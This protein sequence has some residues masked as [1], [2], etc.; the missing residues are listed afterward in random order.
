MICAGVLVAGAATYHRVKRA[1]RLRLA[2]SAPAP[3]NES[4]RP[5]QSPRPTVAK[6][7][8]RSAVP[9]AGTAVPARP[10]T[11]ALETIIEEA[12]ALPA[13]RLSVSA[14]W[15]EGA[16]G[17]RRA[18]DEQARTRAPMLVYFRVDWCPYCRRVD[19]EVLPAPAVNRFLEGVVK[20]RI[21]PE[22]SPPDRSLTE[23][24]GVS[25]YPSLFVIAAPAGKP[26]KVPHF[27]RAG[28]ENIDVTAEKF[29][30]ACEE[31]GLGQ[32]RQLVRDGA[33]KARAGNF[34]GARADLDRAIELDQ[35][36]AE[37]FFWRGYAE[38]RAGDR[39][40]AAGDLKHASELDPKDPFPQAELVGLYQ[41][42]GQQDQAIAAA[43]RLVEVAP[44][45]QHGT[46]FA[47]RG[48]SYGQKGD[49]EHALA[50]F[51]EACR[52]GHTRACGA[53]QQHP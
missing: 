18:L 42:A 32:A 3:A 53:G 39:G 15:Y 30:K 50:D 48:H 19:Q 9:P 44:D 16:E 20:V 2:V 52:R 24:Y 41:R 5:S 38:S 46:G 40:K 21:N 47:L 13:P 49:R 36:S 28:S 33:D 4:A 11:P 25:R 29:V 17:H 26:E 10:A 27:S 35:G 37:A 6:L 12:P 1:R 7:P 34:A 45:W 31:V 22:T 43:S 8:P 23:S 14:S 51:A